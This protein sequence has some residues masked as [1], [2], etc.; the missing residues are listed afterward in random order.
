MNVK[1]QAGNI[2]SGNK[3]LCV[4]TN[5]TE[6]AYRKGNLRQ[7]YP[8]SYH[9]IVY[10]DS[11]SLYQS[12]SR[13]VKNSESECYIACIIALRAK[14]EQYP[15]LNRVIEFNGGVSWLEQCSH[16]VV[17]NMRWEG[18]GRSSGFINCLIV[19]FEQLK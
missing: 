5:P 9:G 10:R 12:L 1:L 14:L 15:F 3:A 2:W 19:A 8:V 7:H 18:N 6:I 11:E 17:G 4:F 13:S 16:H